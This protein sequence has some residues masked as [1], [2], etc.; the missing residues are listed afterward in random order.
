[1]LLLLLVVLIAGFVASAI[2]FVYPGT[3]MN[4]LG[5]FLNLLLGELLGSFKIG[6]GT[7]VT[8]SSEGYTLTLQGVLLVYLPAIV[9]LLLLR[10][11]R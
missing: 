6:L 10:R 5:A 4:T 3:I 9:A 1:M 8:P 11:R 2:P 7:L